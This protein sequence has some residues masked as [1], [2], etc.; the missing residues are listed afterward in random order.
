MAQQYTLRKARVGA[1]DRPAGFLHV[2]LDGLW[3]LADCYNFPEGDLFTKDPV[4]SVALDRLESLLREFDIR[5]TFFIVGR[6]LENLAKMAAVRELSSLGHELAVHTWNH[7]ID[8]ELLDEAQ[9]VDELGRTIEALNE[10]CDEPAVGLRVPGYAAGARSLGVAARLGLRYDGSWLPTPWGPLL[11]LLANRLR[12]DPAKKLYHHEERITAESGTLD[13]EHLIGQMQYGGR[14]PAAHFGRG[15]QPLWFE[16]EQAARLLCLPLATSPVL[17]LPLHA[18]LGM[19]LGTRRVIHALERR[20]RQPWPI[21]YL[22]HG[23]DLLGVA[24]LRGRLPERLER[25]RAFQLS[26]DEKFDFLRTVLAAFKQC[27]HIERTRD[28]MERLETET[29]TTGED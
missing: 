29:P 22:L 24:D 4:F 18:S 21:T 27:T 14:H 26:T 17:G 1:P 10:V 7:R 13:N 11:R 23:M 5:A 15:A 8:L 16:P 20:A 9:I 6:D 3:T 12:D 2:D 28:W 19:M 25:H